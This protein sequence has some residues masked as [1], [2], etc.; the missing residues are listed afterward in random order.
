M[1]YRRLNA[2]TI[3][4]TYSLSR[5]EDRDESL[6][7]AQGFTVLDALGGYWQ[8]QLKEE[9]K[10]KTLLVS[11]LR[12]YIHTHMLSAYATHQ[13]RPN[14]RWMLSYQESGGRRVSFI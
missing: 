14:M 9:D 12:T 2:A 8:V 11:P 10:D 3:P 6:G 1:D 5:T 7:K 4:D 13:V